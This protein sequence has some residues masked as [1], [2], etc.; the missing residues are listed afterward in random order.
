MVRFPLFKTSV[1]LR[2]TYRAA[3]R[4]QWAVGLRSVCAAGESYIREKGGRPA[5]PQEAM[6][7]LRPFVLIQ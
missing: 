4:D 3:R 5:A 1:R 6:R 7:G 2:N